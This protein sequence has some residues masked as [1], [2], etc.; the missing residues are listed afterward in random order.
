MTLEKGDFNKD[1]I[2]I[3]QVKVSQTRNDR[4]ANSIHAKAN[5]K[6]VNIDMEVALPLSK[7]DFYDIQLVKE[8]NYEIGYEKN[9]GDNLSENYFEVYPLNNDG[10]LANDWNE[11][12][13]IINMRISFEIPD[14]ETQGYLFYW[15][16]Y[17]GPLNF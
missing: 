1:T 13:N 4:T 7:F 16:E 8:N 3:K 2:T 11:N 14:I 12:A 10:T 5:H 17:I 9:L 6:F 15:G